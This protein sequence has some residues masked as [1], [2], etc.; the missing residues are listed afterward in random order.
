MLEAKFKLMHK[1]CWTGGL[2][3]FK[4]DF[5]THIT[6]SLTKDFVQD[7]TE[8]SLAK[9]EKSEIKKYF[10]KS[11]IIS[12]W[13]VLEETDKKMTVQIFTDTSKMK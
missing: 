5:C 11:K 1:D 13:G 7:I 8:I 3:K 9:G 12:K 2:S 6:V 10:D 4:S